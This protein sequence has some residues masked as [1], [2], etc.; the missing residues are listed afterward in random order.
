[1]SAIVAKAIIHHFSNTLIGA[2]LKSN[3]LLIAI[4]GI[5]TLLLNAC[6]GKDTPASEDTSLPSTGV[7]TTEQNSTLEEQLPPAQYFT[8]VGNPNYLNYMMTTGNEYYQL[9]NTY[10]GDAI[11]IKYYPEFGHR[12]Y[13]G[14]IGDKWYDYSVRLVLKHENNRDKELELFNLNCGLG[15]CDFNNIHKFAAKCYWSQNH[16]ISFDCEINS[17]T[18]PEFVVD[19]TGFVNEIPL[20]LYT[21]LQICLDQVPPLGDD[22]DRVECTSI[23]SNYATLY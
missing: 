23:D 19:A 8:I 5:F 20:K 7:L 21:E 14:E 18:N 16:S 6:G 12:E 1:L 9:G 10:P 3:T 15:E 22:K 17:D 4:I 2:P 11:E 13:I